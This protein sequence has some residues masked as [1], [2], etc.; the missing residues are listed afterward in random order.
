MDSKDS[1]NKKPKIEVERRR[2]PGVGGAADK[3]RAETP[4]RREQR[5]PGSSQTPKQT[6]SSTQYPDSTGGQIPV[7]AL[8]PLLKRL[9]WW[10]VLLIACVFVGFMVFSMNNGENID[11]VA[12]IQPTQL[13]EFAQPSVQPTKFPLVS[14]PAGENTWLIMLYQDADDKILEQD[15][16]LDL[17]EAER[18]GSSENMHIVAQLDRF[19]GGFQGDGNL[20]NTRRF[21]LTQDDDLNR[22]NSSVVQDLRE[23]NMGEDVPPAYIDLGHFAQILQQYRTTSEVL[24]A[25]Q[26][27]RAAIIQVVVA[28]KHGPKV[29]G[30]SG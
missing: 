4:Q 9:P 22:I 23:V 27:V 17:N 12:Y 11:D 1:N 19:S 29:P 15:I 3:P 10:A 21:Y 6:P 16:F 26:E 28:E 13:Q 25:S 7:E 20:T 2:R 5:S 14:S 24:Q 30:S 18:V 8:I